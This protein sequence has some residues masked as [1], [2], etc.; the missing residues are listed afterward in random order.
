M[1][2][3]KIKVHLFEGQEIYHIHTGEKGNKPNGET[4]R[5]QMDSPCGRGDCRAQLFPRRPQDT[6]AFGTRSSAQVIRSPA[7]SPHTN[8]MMIAFI[9]FKSSLVPLLEGL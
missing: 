6:S 1:A 4:P 9:T 8:M 2:E 3:L 7:L 5:L